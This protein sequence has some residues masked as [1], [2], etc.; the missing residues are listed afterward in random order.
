MSELITD[1]FNY[2]SKEFFRNLDQKEIEK[3]PKNHPDYIALRDWEKK[4]CIEGVNI[5][6]I[7]I[8]GSLYYT[9]N[10]HKIELDRKDNKG[11]ESRIIT[12]PDFR[13]NE[14]I[15]HEE[16][17]L[18]ESEKKGTVIAS[19]RQSGKSETIV[20]LTMRKLFLFQN[21][22]AM[23]MFVT[24]K[25]KQTFTKKAQ[26]AI[27]NGT[28]FLVIPTLD[29]N[30]NKEEFR[31]GV[32]RSDNTNFI[33]SRLF[34]YLNNQGNN[35]ES[36]AGKSLSH[37]FLDE[38]AKE[39]MKETWEALRPAIRGKYG[40]RCSPIMALT[41]GD[42]EKSK[43]AEGIVFN[44]E[45]N[46]MRVHENNGKKTTF[47]LSAIHRPDFKYEKSFIDFYED[48]Y[49]TKVENPSEE[50]KQL[51][52]EV[53]DVEKA[54]RILDEEE[55]LKK[56]ES[57]L[58]YQ[59]QKMYF[60]RQISD[61]FIKGNQNPFVHL[62]DDI[63][64]H[65]ED[66]KANPR[67]LVKE[68]KNGHLMFSDKPSLNSYPLSES[69]KMKIDKV[70]ICVVEDP[71][72]DYVGKAY[73]AGLDP[74]NTIK[75][76]TSVSLGSW[77]IIKKMTSNLED[78]YNESIVSWYNGRNNINQFREDILSSLT[79]Y[80]TTLLHEAA[81]DN[82]TQWFI[83]KDE[84]SRLE[85]NYELNKQINPKTRAQN[86]KGMRPNNKTQNF[87]LE[88]TLQYLEEE[89]PNGKKGLT[90]IPDI[91]LLEQILLFSGDLS[92]MDALV[93]FGHALMHLHMDRRVV[94]RSWD[95]S[96]VTEQSVTKKPK[97]MFKL[98]TKPKKS[99]I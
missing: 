97:D 37:V 24:S 73:V 46:D 76:E 98:F 22:E 17:N 5:N 99:I 94:S 27:E 83:D 42:V 85:S 8:W 40:L 50:L 30:W 36:G 7:H 63:D 48:R 10:H 49:N 66:L 75:T 15:I 82:L 12:F 81:D 4:K 51:R 71:I 92:P 21:T 23:G 68:F 80:D 72:K 41:G 53:A 54:N 87:M 43:D 6:G 32:K 38:I 88:L 84:Y 1:I 19:C 89:L 60:P 69:E 26:V 67:H 3:I 93:A 29:N 79:A 64:A 28:D 52:I 47:F 65:I 18:A 11:N 44:P 2:K 45:A 39:D 78:P 9:L 70:G 91:Y 59:K 34:L 57:L 31:F 33:Y 62:K 86:A 56:K 55:E 14:W 90:R 13:D 74:F 95:Y 61:M 58:S 20:S 16:Y 35:T 77:Y 96:N 25:D